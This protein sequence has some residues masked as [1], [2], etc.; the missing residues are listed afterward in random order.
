[1][2]RSELLKLLREICGEI[3]EKDCSHVSERD[4]L[5]DVG[6]DSMGN[7]ELAA[8]LER[9][10]G[11]SIPDSSLVGVRRVDQLLEVVEKC[12][13]DRDYWTPERRISTP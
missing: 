10:L 4:E 7:L 12:D 3:L 13:G 8:A 5:T 6:L 2:A 1:M 9:R 11:V